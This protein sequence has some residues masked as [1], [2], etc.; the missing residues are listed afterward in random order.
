MRAFFKG[1]AC[2]FCFCVYFLA[3][4]IL[5]FFFFF[6]AK[7]TKRRWA[8]RCIRVFTRCLL[9]LLGI[10]V[11]VTGAVEEARKLRG[12]FLAPNHL[13]YIDGFAMA[14]TFPLIFVSKS[15]LKSWPLIG[16][17]TQLSGTIFIDRS[18]RNHLVDSIREMAVTLAQGT[19]VLFFPEGTTTNGEAMLAFKSTFFDAPVQTGA[20]VV[21]VSIVYHRVDGEPFSLANRDRICWYGDMTFWDHFVGLL[22]CRTVEMSL[23]IHRP[24]WADAPAGN[25]D[26]R[27]DLSDRTYAAVAGGVRLLLT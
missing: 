6:L 7:R 15:D 21:P 11:R 20:T 12:A 9:K 13:S 10:R 24:I 4:V 19:H 14:A 1:L 8:A 22:R 17:M 3:E 27:K 5:G 2:F 23:D 25:S 26:V 16:W 18:R